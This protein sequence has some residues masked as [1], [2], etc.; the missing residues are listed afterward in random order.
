MKPAPLFLFAAL[1]FFY[2]PEIQAQ[3]P[4]GDTIASPDGRYRVLR[5]FVQQDEI[6]GHRQTL[7]QTAT[8]DTIPIGQ[9]LTYDSPGARIFWTPDSRVLITETTMEGVSA[10]Q[11]RY[12]VVYNLLQF[13]L[14]KRFEG[15]LLAFDE[16]NGVVFFYR[17]GENFASQQLWVYYLSNSKTKLIN[18][19][20]FKPDMQ[21]PEVT[22]EP[23]SRKGLVR[24][25]SAFSEESIPFSY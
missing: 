3:Q 20:P 4:A 5:T 1:A 13:K 21:L 24:V 10:D 16:K 2:L 17:P 14:L 25:F 8:G 23:K 11:R 7:Q 6:S 18:N 9:L 12:I 15:V 22:F 19:Y